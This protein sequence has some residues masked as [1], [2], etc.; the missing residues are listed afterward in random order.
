MCGA[1]GDSDMSFGPVGHFGWHSCSA[2]LYHKLFLPMSLSHA[3]SQHSVTRTT[4][5]LSRTQDSAD[6]HNSSGLTRPAQ[7]SGAW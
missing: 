1:H 6:S 7:N 2:S 3:L 5:F 4:N